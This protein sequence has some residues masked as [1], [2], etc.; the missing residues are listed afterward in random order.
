MSHV[1]ILQY[2][3]GNKEHEQVITNR[4]FELINSLGKPMFYGITYSFN[5]SQTTDDTIIFDIKPK[6]GLTFKDGFV[7]KRNDKL[8]PHFNMNENKTQVG[9]C[10]RF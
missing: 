5:A 8:E 3:L 4:F 7:E 1:E 10:Y 2:N 9:F 6:L